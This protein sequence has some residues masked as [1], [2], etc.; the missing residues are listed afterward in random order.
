MVGFM[1]D[2]GPRTQQLDNV[3]AEFFGRKTAFPT[4][5]AALARASGAPIVVAVTKRERDNSFRGIALPPIFVERTK[6]TAEDLA[7]ATQAVVRALEGLV[8][9]DPDQWYIFRPM[10][11]EPART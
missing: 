3:Q 10:W 5:A 9:P 8:R 6:Q 11:P 4:I 2:L 1:M 7:S